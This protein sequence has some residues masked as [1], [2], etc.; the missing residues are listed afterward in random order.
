METTLRKFQFDGLPERLQKAFAIVEEVLFWQNHQFIKKDPL[1]KRVL[2][3]LWNGFCFA[4][5]GAVVVASWQFG[6][7]PIVGAIISAVVCAA[8]GL[9]AAVSWINEDLLLD[10]VKKTKVNL[11]FAYP[12]GFISSVFGEPV[13]YLIAK[14]HTSR[15]RKIVHE[16]YLSKME[17]SRFEQ[18]ADLYVQIIEWNKSVVAINRALALQKAHRTN[19]TGLDELIEELEIVDEALMREVESAND[20]LRDGELGDPSA[21]AADL[22]NLIEANQERFEKT[23]TR[24]TETANKV[25]K[26]RAQMEVNALAGRTR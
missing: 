4:F 9:G 22:S 12:L 13:L 7:L 14:A 16:R 18:L 15:V 8:L 11:W 20:I 3:G 5:W 26:A 19:L 21:I 2:K 1:Y 17:D 25:Q 23:R 10:S 6:V 24:I